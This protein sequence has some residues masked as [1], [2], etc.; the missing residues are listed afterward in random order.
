MRKVEKTT[1]FLAGTKSPAED[2]GEKTAFETGCSVSIH[3]NEH[4]EPDP[5]DRDIIDRQWSLNA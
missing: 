2:A 1:R 5:Q 4:Y 3:Q